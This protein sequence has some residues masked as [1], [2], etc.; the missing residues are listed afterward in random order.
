MN[1]RL[2][3]RLALTLLLVILSLEGALYVS[4]WQGLVEDP[5]H[6][7]F[8]R[9][10]EAT[11]AWQQNRS[12]YDSTAATARRPDDGEYLDVNPPHAHLLVLPLAHLEPLPALIAWTVFSACALVAVVLV[13]VMTV[14]WS[15][16]PVSTW[17]LFAAALLLF[18][19]TLAN[20]WLAQTGWLVAALVTGVWGAGRTGRTRTAGALLGV[21]V[22]LKPFL[23]PL[24]F[25][26]AWRR[27]WRGLVV[28]AVTAGAMAT[29]GAAVFG[30]DAFRDWV[31][32]LGRIDWEVVPFN[33]SLYGFLSRVFV[34]AHGMSFVP[35]LQ[36][37]GLAFAAWGLLG[38]T[39]VGA[40]AWRARAARGD[41]DAAFAVLALAGVLASPL[42][43]V[44]YHPVVAGPL[45][46][47][48]LRPGSAAVPR[49]AKGLLV[50]AALALM[51]PPVALWIGH[52][53]PWATLTVGSAYFW[54]TLGLWA[55]LLWTAAAD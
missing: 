33:A 3:Q 16:T 12:L 29:A 37:P 25:W 18:P 44:Y 8:G 24:V 50:A 47:L 4:L 48:A 2:L 1:P 35:P 53:A 54:G 49:G 30:L 10:Y 23:V 15:G 51:W 9:F 11:R 34:P 28:A 14:G 5:T 52:P 38:T 36:A 32:T 43:W 39:I 55:W 31:V 17:I 7:D 46:S 26:F 6:R 21:V 19:G 41:P 13:V 42:G 27:E 22:S 20:F 45:A 40:S